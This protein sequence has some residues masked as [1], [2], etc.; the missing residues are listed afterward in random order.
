MSIFVVV[1]TT[2]VGKSALAVKLAK[3][4]SGHV[5]NADSMQVYKGL[6]IVTNKP[7]ANE[8]AMAPHHLFDFLDPAKEYSVSE[9]SRDATAIIDEL[10]TKNEPSVICGGTNY[11]IQSLLWSQSIIETATTPGLSNK[12]AI[13]E[14]AHHSLDPSLADTLCYLLEHT[15]PRTNTPDQISE[16]SKTAPFHDT[17]KQIDPVMA[18]RW[19]PNDIRKIRRSLEVFYTT[20]ISHSDWY[21][22]QRNESNPDTRLRYPTCVFWLYGRPDKLN[23]RL[24]ARVDQMIDKGMFDEL[25]DMR[26]KMTK[27][28]VVGVQSQ[29]TRGILQAIGFKEFHDYFVAEEN[30]EIDRLDDLRMKGI[31]EMKI[32][33]RQYAKRQVSW[34]KNKLAPQCVIEHEEGSGALYLIDATDVENLN[35]DLYNKVIELAQNFNAKKPNE[36]STLLAPKLDDLDLLSMR[37][38]DASEWEQ[39]TCDVCTIKSTG[40]KKIL[41][42]LHEWETHLKS[43]VHKKALS[44]IKKNQ[45]WQEYIEKQKRQ[46]LNADE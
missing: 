15:D 23:P 17:L 8:L 30:G 2:G 26:K 31:E 3:A 41:N 6:D 37:I 27:N 36:S 45:A 12:A 29:Y 20:G 21:A 39:Y 4:L 32:A 46:K 24:D 19:H 5:I 38:A 9:F 14:S 16:F 22:S 35:D 1:G 7:D 40:Q 33:T 18:Q 25:N 11:Y 43:G 13:L 28:E 10:N 34:I 42:G 44:Y